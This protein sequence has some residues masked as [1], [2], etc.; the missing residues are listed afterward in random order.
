MNKI[1]FFVSLSIV[2]LGSCSRSS[3]SG[4]TING[5]VSGA[6]ADK[7]YLE[8]RI[9]RQYIPIDSAT[10]ENGQFTFSGKLDEPLYLAFRANSSDGRFPVFLEN[11][12]MSLTLDADTPDS[13]SLSGSPSQDLFNAYNKGIESFES[14]M[15]EIYLEYQKAFKSNDQEDMARLDS[16]YDIEDQGEKSYLSEWIKGHGESAVAAWLTDRNAYRMNLDE[17]QEFLGLYSSDV[18]KG[19]YGK[20]VDAYATLLAAVQVGKTAPDFTLDGPDGQP[21]TLSQFRGGWLLVDFWASWCRP[22]R[23][24]NPNV[25]KAYAEYHPKGFQILGVSLDT[26]KEN[27]KKAIQDDGIT[28]AQ[29]SDLKGWNN[30]AGKLYAVRS[31]PH[32]VLLDPNGVISAEDLRGDALVAK[33]KEIYK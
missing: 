6:T 33:L 7:V 3:D 2:I 10:V 15:N 8:E 14:A 32:T 21:V 13:S 9:D 23:M 19:K 16:L 26:K 20:S 17:L 12:V 5:T 28:W 1:I 31:I 29:C 25:V 11:A 18:R 22:C 4:Y 30:E 27:W 24:E